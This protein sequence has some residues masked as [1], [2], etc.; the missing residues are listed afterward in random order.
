[1]F[2]KKVTDK[3]Y[4]K[5]KGLTDPIPLTSKTNWSNL[6]HDQLKEKLRVAIDE[7]NRLKAINKK[8]L[9]KKVEIKSDKAANRIIEMVCK[10]LFI[11]LNTKYV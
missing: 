5:K 11:D 3:I 2:A 4:R 9:K 10:I 1:M 7:L 6:S 8:L